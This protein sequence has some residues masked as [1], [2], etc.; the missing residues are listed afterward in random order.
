MATQFA[1]L[2]LLPSS[3]ALKLLKLPVGYYRDVF[4]NAVYDSLFALSLTVFT[5]SFS[6][7]TFPSSVK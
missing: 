3:P 2:S 5:A 4:V 7:P 6:T 1:P